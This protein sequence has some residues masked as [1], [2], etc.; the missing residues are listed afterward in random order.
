[1]KKTLK[2]LK[3]VGIVA[4]LL[5][6]F[7]IT[8]KRTRRKVVD[9][10]ITYLWLDDDRNDVLTH[11]KRFVKKSKLGDKDVL[12]ISIGSSDID[13][14]RRDIYTLNFKELKEICKRDTQGFYEA[15]PTYKL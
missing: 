10:D 11:L 9:N 6:N 8:F 4:V 5:V 15:I 13:I 3:V 14:G 2:V 12:C 1:M 7:K